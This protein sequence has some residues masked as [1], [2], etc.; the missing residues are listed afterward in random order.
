M[1][2]S[3][4]GFNLSATG[5]TGKLGELDWVLILA[6]LITSSFLILVIEEFRLFGEFGA[7]ED[8]KSNIS[9]F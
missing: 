9:V 1:K 3:I 6:F 2:N 4:I 7:F 5:E 8:D